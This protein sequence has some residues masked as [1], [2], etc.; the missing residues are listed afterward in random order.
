MRSKRLIVLVAC[1]SALVLIFAVG[2]GCGKKG[3]SITSIAPDTG[4]AGTEVKITGENFG[5]SQGDGVVHVG[6]GVAD[7]VAWSEL[8]ITVKVP[9]GLPA[10]AQGISVLTDVGESNQVDFTVT[11]AQL[12]QPE[13]K[14][15]EVEHISAVQAMIAFMQSKGVSTEGMTFSVVQISAKDRNWKIDEATE[16]GAP[17]IYFLLHNENGD[18]V[19]KDDGTA[20]SKA[21][22]QAK[23][24]PSDLFGTPTPATQAQAFQDYLKKQ[25]INPA[26]LSVTIARVSKTDPTWQ[27]G[28]ARKAGQQD[29]MVIFHKVGGNWTVVDMGTGFTNAQLKQLGVPADLIHTPT[30]AQAIATFIQSGNAEPGVTET[31]WAL[32]VY[33]VSRIDPDWEVVKGIQTGGAGV[34]YFVLHWENGQWV[35]KD[36]GGQITAGSIPG[37]PSDITAP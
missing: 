8:K 20:L 26:G 9:S 2:A 28:V 27:E 15:G 23:G 19:V 21:E 14:E 18:W 1:C 17:T 30:E 10:A 22:L 29:A 31:G 16:A 37:M 32:S 11:G 7:V 5:T 6:T 3:P 12:Q 4:P 36:D 35:V 13:R 33:K 34:N 25:G 24:A